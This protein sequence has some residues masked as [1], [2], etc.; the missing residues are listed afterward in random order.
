MP[1]KLRTAA[2][3]ATVLWS[4]PGCAHRAPKLEAPLGRVVVYRNG[5]AYFER[6]ATV[7]GSFSIEVPRARVDDFLKSLTVVDLADQSPLSVSYRTPAATSS[8]SIAM[9]IELPPGKRDVLITYVTE[10]PSWKPSYRLTLEGD[11][12]AVLQSLAV[13]DNVSNEAWEDVRVGVGTT[14]ALSFRYDLHTVRMV[15]RQRL[16]SS[17]RLALAPPQGGSTYSA[18]GT[19]QRVL[20]NVAME[21]FRNIPSGSETSRDYTQVVESSA[22][23][24]DDSAGISLA[25]TTASETQIHRPR[26]EHQHPELRISQPRVEVRQASR[27]ATPN[28]G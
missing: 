14:S 27:A 1:T 21:D 17:E 10:S 15:E 19:Q 9:T 26:R 24:S 7:D 5:V 2:L 22:T 25:G 4:A 3:L 13:V 23:A 11:S 20:A 16:E 12:S 28:S 18:G 8:A 6:R